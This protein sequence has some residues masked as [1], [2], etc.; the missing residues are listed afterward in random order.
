MGT[1]LLGDTAPQQPAGTAASA[2]LPPPPL[3]LFP[4]LLLQAAGH[5]DHSMP[6]P[7]LPCLRKKRK[8]KNYKAACGSRLA[9]W[10]KAAALL[11]QRDLNQA[12]HRPEGSEHSANPVERSVRGFLL[13]QRSGLGFVLGLL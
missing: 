4:L 2:H 13:L 1:P 6:F 5:G 8:D 12:V 10:G 7:P 3:P 11:L 9:E